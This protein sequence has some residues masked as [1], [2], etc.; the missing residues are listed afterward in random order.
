MSTNVT[1]SPNSTYLPC[2]PNGS[3]NLTKSDELS[4]VNYWD[5]GRQYGQYYAKKNS[6]I[7][8][9]SSPILVFAIFFLFI[10]QAFG[11]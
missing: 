10:G 5:C 6:A 8:L 9:K 11:L 4:P 3:I 7:S 1:P 2:A